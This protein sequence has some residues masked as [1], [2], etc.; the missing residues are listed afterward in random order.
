M[1]ATNATNST[2]CCPPQNAIKIDSEL[3]L[4]NNFHKG[5]MGEDII[6]AA[7]TLHG[8][9]IIPLGIEHTPALD[10]SEP[11]I[12]QDPLFQV[13]RHAP[14]FLAVKRFGDI[15]NYI[16]V[17]SKFWPS[18]NN[19][20]ELYD[21]IRDAAVRKYLGCL[22]D[23][24]GS[25]LIAPNG[26]YAKDDLG[27]ARRSL[28]KTISVMGDV[29]FVIIALGDAY[30]FRLGNIVYGNSENRKSGLRSPWKIGKD[31]NE[32]DRAE[33]LSI[34]KGNGKVRCPEWFQA[35]FDKIRKF[36]Q[37][38]YPTLKQGI[39]MCGKM[40]LSSQCL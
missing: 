2:Q 10:A 33:K 5:R 35:D 12:W 8:Y 31:P 20:S 13:L 34:N 7:F 17:E 22:V 11:Y 15:F 26:K 4:L 6:R 23:R 36:I 32:T 38:N 21:W 14:D 19:K 40:Y 37:D 25:R 29:R 16:Y 30:I 9:H 39:E 18:R 27:D 24:N 28:Q 1:S 3:A